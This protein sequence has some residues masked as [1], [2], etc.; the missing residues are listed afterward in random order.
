MPRFSAPAGRTPPHSAYI[1]DEALSQVESGWLGAPRILDGQGCF[2][3][4]PAF[5]I[6]N[7]FRFAVVQRP[8]IRACGD[9]KD[10][11]TN[12]S[13]GVNTP[14]PPHIRGDMSPRSLMIFVWLAEIFPVERMANPTITRRCRLSLR[15]L[16]WRLSHFRDPA[17]SSMNVPPARKYLA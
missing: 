6:N 4:A 10:A 14:I 11:E 3:D 8:K 5:P 1:W 15:F 13:F 7:A 12:R 2:N 17:L 9:L 16:F